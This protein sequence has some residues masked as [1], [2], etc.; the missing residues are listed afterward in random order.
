MGAKVGEPQEGAISEINVTPLVDV[1][2]V[3]LVVFMI[4]SFAIQSGVSVPLP[5]ATTAHE[6]QDSGNHIVISINSEGDLFVGN[7]KLSIEE[8]IDAVNA[9]Y[10]KNPARSLL[11]KGSKELHYGQVREV[12]DVLAENGMTTLLLATEKEAPAEGGH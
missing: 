1:M 8:L 6:Q 12:M 4:A 5:V 10:R 3:L 7:E 11:I 9:E 2:L